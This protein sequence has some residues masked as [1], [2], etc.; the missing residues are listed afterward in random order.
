MK[1]RIQVLL[2]LITISLAGN[3]FAQKS[4]KLGHFN[5][6]DLI[7][8]MPEGDSAQV[9]LKKHMEE[10]QS[11]ADAM[12]K[13][14]QRL[15]TEYQAKEAQLSDLLKQSKQ[16]EIQSVE[17]RFREFQQNA[18]LDL[19]KKREALMTKITDRIKSAVTEIAKEQKFTYIF[20]STGILWYAEESEDISF[21]ILKKLNIK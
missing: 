8:K 5:S 15:I 14:Y 16:K 19:Q 7:Q 4:I 9:E 18:E 2:L 12:Q 11:E 1:R 20:E 13:E 17:E 6:A 3:S 10:L 21:L